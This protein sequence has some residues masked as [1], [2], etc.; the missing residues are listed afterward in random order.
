MLKQILKSSLLLMLII[1]PIQFTFAEYNEKSTEYNLVIKPIDK[2]TISINGRL[3][4]DPSK[5]REMGI[6]DKISPKEYMH[7]LRQLRI[8]SAAH[9]DLVI[10]VSEYKCDSETNTCTCDNTDF[11]DCS[12]MIAEECSGVPTGTDGNSCILQPGSC[13]CEWHLKQ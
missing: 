8:I 11:F 9:P 6:A 13:T 2:E 5:L 1:L 7:L 10:S 12:D 3:T 4:L